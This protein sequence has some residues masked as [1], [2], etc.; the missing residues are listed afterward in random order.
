MSKKAQ[1]GL[2][3]T[4]YGDDC[5]VDDGYNDADPPDPN[6]PYVRP[7]LVHV[8]YLIDIAFWCLDSGRF[9]RSVRLSK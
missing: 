8:L 3:L 1:R 4:D 2:D 9:L 7:L 5:Y 6:T